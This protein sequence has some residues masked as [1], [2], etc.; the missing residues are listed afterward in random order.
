MGKSGYSLTSV[1]NFLEG[2]GSWADR[3]GFLEGCSNIEKGSYYIVD[4]L[5][6]IYQQIIYF[7]KIT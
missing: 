5:I 1:C 3:F 2:A 6:Y 4:N 7:S